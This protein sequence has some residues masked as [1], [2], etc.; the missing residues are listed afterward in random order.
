MTQIEQQNAVGA[1]TEAPSSQDHLIQLLEG[2]KPLGEEYPPDLFAARRAAFIAQIT[3]YNGAGVPENVLSPDPFVELLGSLKPVTAAYP[4]EL[5]AAR[6]ASFISQVERYTG[7]AV[8]EEQLSSQDGRLFKLLE[9]LKSFEIE[10]PLKMLSARRAGFITQIR[11]GKTSVL[12]AF[13]FAVRNLFTP[14]PRQAPSAPTMSFRRVSL[15]LAGMLIAAFMGSLLYEN[16]QPLAVLLPSPAQSEVSPSNPVAEVTTTGEVAQVICKPGYLPPLCLAK[17]FDKTRD[18]TFPGNGSARPAV[19]KDTIPG[20]SRIHQ[21]A[22]VNDGLYGPGAS[23]IS[24]S[25]YSWIKIDLGEVRRINTIAFGRDRLGNLN[26]GD[27]GQFIIAVAIQDDVYEDGDS[28]NDLNEYT[29]VYNSDEVGF[30]G[31]VSGPETIQANFEPI[32]ARFVKITFENPRTAVDEIEVFMIQPPSYAATSTH[33]SRDTVAPPTFT[34]IPT[35]TLVPSKT[36]TAIPTNTFIPTRTAT[37]RPTFTPRPTNTDV[38]T[39]TSVPPT[40]TPVPPTDTPVPPTDTSEPPTDT[41]EPPPT[42][43]SEPPTEISDPPTVTSEPQASI[44]DTPEALL[45]P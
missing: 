19:A 6:R 43:T 21:A 3:E 40:D 44:T 32:L 13:R 4:P 29:Q 5:L 36:F 23:W 41:P 34:P 17:E 14:R 18:L 22:Y 38:P 1:D 20:Y 12:D 15:V 39:F 2:L 11:D 30:D 8:Q 33:R 26:D 24:N 28:S 10:Y 45:G 16:R 27:P 9:R 7:V 42:D 31:I 37:P 35:N 25:A